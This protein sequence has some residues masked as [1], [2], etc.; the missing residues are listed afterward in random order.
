MILRIGAYRCI[1]CMWKNVTE[2]LFDDKIRNNS[3]NVNVLFKF[4]GFGFL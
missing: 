1:L 2:K 3:L 4:D